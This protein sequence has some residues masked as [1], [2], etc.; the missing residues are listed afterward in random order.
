MKKSVIVSLLLLAG[1]AKPPGE[2]AAAAIATDP[3]LQR[4]C[5]SLVAERADKRAALEQL[6]EHQEETA[7]R[8][9]AWMAIVH[10][11]V[12]S[13]SRGDKEAEISRLKGHLRAIDE[14][15]R[16]KGCS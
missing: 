5:D 6:S 7:K 14:A 13:M 15:M 10:V 8:D 12:A 11:P 4:N 16:A 3:Y 1:C 9:A 2:I